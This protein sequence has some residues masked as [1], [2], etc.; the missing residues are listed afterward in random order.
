MIKAIIFDLDGVIADTDR[1]RFGM[2]KSIL[3]KRGI[4]LDDM[5]YSRSVGKDTKAFLKECF[6]RTVSDKDIDNISEEKTR[7][8][9]ASPE[10]YITALPHAVECINELYRLGY[11]LAVSSSSSRREMQLIL[12]T[13]RV[14]KYFSV[15]A[16]SE[17]AKNP[18]PDPQIYLECIRQ[19]GLPR[20]QCIAVEDSRNGIMAAKA[21]GIAC[22]A[23]STDRGGL[24]RADVVLGTLEHLTDNLIR[25]KFGGGAEKARG[26]DRDVRGRRRDEGFSAE[27]LL[28][29]EV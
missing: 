15:I 9:L 5:F 6:G 20:E 28:R 26:Q 18:K 21:A 11:R 12:D 13:L 7:E 14:A 22:I 10:K 16:G 25:D 29:G 8:L 27:G 1:T 4:Y 24:D 2:L 19:L 17:S 23:V 3:R